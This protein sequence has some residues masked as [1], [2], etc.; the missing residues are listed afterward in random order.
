MLARFPPVNR[1]SRLTAFELLG[2]RNCRFASVASS[3]MLRKVRIGSETAMSIEPSSAPIRRSCLVRAPF[4]IRFRQRIRMDLPAL[5][6]PISTLS[7]GLNSKIPESAILLMFWI[8]TDETFSLDVLGIGCYTSHSGRPD[9]CFARRLFCDPGPVGQKAPSLVGALKTTIEEVVG[10]HLLGTALIVAPIRVRNL[11]RHAADVSCDR[12]RS[13]RS[14]RSFSRVDTIL[15]KRSLDVGG[16]RV[17][18]P[19]SSV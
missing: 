14:P 10:S 1:A 11:P 5:F 13:S 12:P 2:R 8:R 4:W 16:E 9:A 18:L 3:P 15:Y 19:T 7:R 17:E 6:C